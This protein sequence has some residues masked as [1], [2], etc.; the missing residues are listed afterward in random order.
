ML[1][2]IFIAHPPF[3]DGLF[4]GGHYDRPHCLLLI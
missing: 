4:K 2:V 1:F 3:F